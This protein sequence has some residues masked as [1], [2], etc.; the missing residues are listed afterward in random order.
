[1]LI[2]LLIPQAR[3]LADKLAEDSKIHVKMD[4]NRTQTDL[5]RLGSSNI[6]I[7]EINCIL[8]DGECGLTGASV[9]SGSEFWLTVCSEGVTVCVV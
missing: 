4:R 5:D 9:E 8:P 7:Q 6:Q 3:T 2:L 1:M